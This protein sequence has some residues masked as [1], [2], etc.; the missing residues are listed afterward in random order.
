[1]STI[2]SFFSSS[3]RSVGIVPPMFIYDEV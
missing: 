3:T 1:M 2:G